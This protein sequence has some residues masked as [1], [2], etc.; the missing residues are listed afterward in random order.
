MGDQTEIGKVLA[1]AKELA[2]AYYRLT[3]KPLGVTGEVGE[4]EAARLLKLDLVEARVPGYDAIGPDGRRY[5]VKSR[6]LS[7]EARK[8]SGQRLGGIKLEHDWDAVLFVLMDEQL[9]TIEIWL[10]ERGAVTDAIMRP[11][12]KA[13]NERGALAISKFRQIGS[14]VWHRQSHAGLDPAYRNP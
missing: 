7:A 14:K 6:A 10:A 2:A 11:G 8:K 9:D 12:S 5:Q 4:Y 3:G 13:R 1:Q